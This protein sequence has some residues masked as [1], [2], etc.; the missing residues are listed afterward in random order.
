[1]ILEP[2]RSVG[3]FGLGYTV[4]RWP[5]ATHHVVRIGTRE[6]RVIVEVGETAGIRAIVALLIAGFFLT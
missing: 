1:M 5:R 4:Q 6:L 3:S 2:R